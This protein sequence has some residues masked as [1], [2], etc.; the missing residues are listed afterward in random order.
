MAA[1]I[2]CRG[3]PQNLP[4]AV[5]P[6]HA[7]HPALESLGVLPR[8]L[9]S[10]AFFCGPTHEKLAPHSALPLGTVKSHIRRALTAPGKVL[11]PDM[12]AL[13]TRA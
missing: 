9:L 10:L 7:Q 11:P 8:Q 6:H 4:E 12:G 13:E 2:A 5:Q 1:E 3:G